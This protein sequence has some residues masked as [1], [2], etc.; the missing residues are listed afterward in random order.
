MA[1]GA[2]P[3]PRRVDMSHYNDASNPCFHGDSIV[4]LSNGSS[5]PVN[6]IKK[7]D[8]VRC[9]FGEAAEVLCVVK[10]HCQS[11]ATSLVQLSPGLRLTPWHPVMWNGKWSFPSDLEPTHTAA[12]DAVYSLVLGSS[13]TVLIGGIACVTLGHGLE[14]PVVAHPYLGTAKVVQDL[15]KLG[16]WDA[17]RIEFADGCMLRT[18]GGLVQ[19]LDSTKLL[20]THSMSEVEGSVD[21]TWGTNHTAGMR[22]ENGIDDTRLGTSIA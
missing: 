14:D 20:F 16:G 13:H 8:L 22:I 5:K 3:A 4:T 19:G 18:S 12:C 9:A 2:P 1:G 10:T 6:A 17:G 15:Q 11:R 7:G 21:R